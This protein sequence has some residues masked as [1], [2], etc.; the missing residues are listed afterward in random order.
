MAP[1]KG[2]EV[3]DNKERLEAIKK[4]FNEG[5]MTIGSG[6]CFL[7]DGHVEWLIEKVEQLE[8][9]N[10]MFRLR[11]ERR[12]ERIS[13]LED[14]L[15]EEMANSV[16]IS[17]KLNSKEKQL[18]QAQAKIERYKNA[19]IHIGNSLELHE[20]FF[21]REMSFVAQQALEGDTQ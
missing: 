8:R 7:S 16:R 11:L 10:E 13:H 15:D 12:S 3:M 1:R 5:K 19:L 9:E 20:D 2:R 17:Q 18:Q 4:Q 14:K 6:A 21:V